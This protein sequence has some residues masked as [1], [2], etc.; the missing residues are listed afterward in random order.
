MQVVLYNRDPPLQ[1]TCMHVSPAP[2]YRKRLER[3]PILIYMEKKEKVG[4]KRRVMPLCYQSLRFIQ[5]PM[6]E[7]KSILLVLS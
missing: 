7:G 4:E 5:G 2:N 1:F 6:R 3:P